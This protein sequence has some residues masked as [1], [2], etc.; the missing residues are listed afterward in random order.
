MIL[1]DKLSLP[2]LTFKLVFFSQI[3]NLNDQKIGKSIC[4][5]IDIISLFYHILV[6]EQR[7]V[8]LIQKKEVRVVI[9]GRG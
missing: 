5:D 9:K 7:C 8:Y 2:G 1:A 6:S 3:M 4:F